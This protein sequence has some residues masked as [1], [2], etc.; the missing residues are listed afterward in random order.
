MVNQVYSPANPAYRVTCAE[1]FNHNRMVIPQEQPTQ[2]QSYY[3][4]FIFGGL[5]GQASKLAMRLGRFDENSFDTLQR[6]YINYFDEKKRALVGTKKPLSSITVPR[7]GEETCSGIK[8]AQL[9]SL[10]M[11]ILFSGVMV[12][13]NGGEGHR[14]IFFTPMSGTFAEQIAGFLKV[15]PKHIASIMSRDDNDSQKQQIVDLNVLNIVCASFA[16]QQIINNKSDLTPSWLKD[17]V[18]EVSECIP[19]HTGN[20]HKE[21]NK[22]CGHDI[23]QILGIEGRLDAFR[24][25]LASNLGNIR[26]MPSEGI[27]TYIKNLCTSIPVPDLM[28]LAQASNTNGV[29]SKKP[30]VNATSPTHP[31]TYNNP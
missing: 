3:F 26:S 19:Y 14:N 12:I 21:E 6:Y 27:Q 9:R 20:T 7:S 1:A 30:R 2:N 23:L 18:I 25:I 31:N 8:H 29:K 13:R 17:Y 11:N 16:F 28:P 5:S 10:D 15:E 22:H 4:N 24:Q